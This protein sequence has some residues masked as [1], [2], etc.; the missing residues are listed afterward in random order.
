MTDRIGQ[1]RIHVVASDNGAYP[2]IITAYVPDT[3]IFEN[4]LKT[5]RKK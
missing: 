2:K 4:D 3:K 1:R 5:R